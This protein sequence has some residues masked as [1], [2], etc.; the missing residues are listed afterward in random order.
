M[1]T[2]SDRPPQPIRWQ[3]AWAQGV[4]DPRVLMRLLDLPT[5]GIAAAPPPGFPLR[6]PHGFIARM[7]K[8]DPND[9]LL[10]QV[11]PVLAESARVPGF[12]RDPVADLAA[13]VRPGLLHKYHGRVLLLLGGACAIHCRYCFRR[14]FPY[15]HAAQARSEQWSEALAYIR[16]DPSIKEVIL[17][18]GDPLALADE[19]LS[20]LAHRLSAIPHLERLRVHSR[21][22]VVLPERVDG[23]LLGW[24]AGT[25]LLPIVVVHANHP[26]EVDAS[27]IAALAR[28]RAAGVTV[29]NQSVLLAGVNDDLPALL[30]LST[31]LFRAGALPY[32]LHLLDPV[33]G[34]AHFEVPRSRALDLLEGLRR[35]LPGYLVPRLVREQPGAP[36][37]LPAELIEV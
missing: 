6:V 14:H 30:D 27:V 24:L 32:Y 16:Q 37:K 21:L 29:L 8:G 15:Q 33:E 34:A 13:E 12:A 25:R 18:G 31:A 5:D 4:S 10:R 20:E 7:R 9:P 23:A 28:L 11:L 1:I 35:R 26:N 3:A 36:Y 2:Q 22:P 17:S 19:R